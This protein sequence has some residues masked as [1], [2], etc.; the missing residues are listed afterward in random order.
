MDMEYIRS[1]ITELRIQ[2]GISEYQ[3]SYETGHSKNYIHNIVAGH[4]QPSAKELLYIIEALGTTPRDFFDDMK[5]RQNPILAQEIIK[6]LDGMAE[7]DLEV[8]LAVVRRLRSK[9]T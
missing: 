5:T 2:R 7:E 4:S 3:L 1:R 9:E 6:G 8:V